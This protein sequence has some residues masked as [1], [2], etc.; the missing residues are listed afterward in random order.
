MPV[1][2]II[3]DIDPL[4][5]SILQSTR[6]GRQALKRRGIPT[7][8]KTAY[9][10][11]RKAKTRG[12]G[13]GVKEIGCAHALYLD[14]YRDFGRGIKRWEKRATSKKRRRIYAVLAACGGCNDEGGNHNAKS[15]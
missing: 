4:Y 9:I 8:P 14:K 11:R 3:S 12:R 10:R 5:L 7:Q 13:M 2:T 15:L 1:Q 6:K